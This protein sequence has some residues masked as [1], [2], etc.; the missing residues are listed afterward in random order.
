MDITF[1]YHD[2]ESARDLIENVIVPLYEASHQD[3][4]SNPFFSAERFA[5]RTR[6]YMKAPG[7]GLVVTNIHGQAIGQTFGYSLPVNAR[8]WQGLTTPVPD[9][10]TEETGTRTFALNE[11]MVVPEWQGKG[12]AHATHDA[13]LRSR[14][15]QRAT[16]LVRED[17]ESAQR[18]YLRWGWRKVA[19]L[20]PFPD[21]PHFDA[22]IIELPLG[23]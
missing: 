18:A 19:K 6:G 15:E 21:S 7:F 9:G 14:R 20:Q 23:Q 8:W 1:Q 17:N 16:L 2:A 3:V 22:M 12:I 4:I 11:L 5:E 10:F 13:L